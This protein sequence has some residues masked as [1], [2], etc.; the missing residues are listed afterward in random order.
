MMQAEQMRQMKI[1]V[2]HLIAF[3]QQKI[4]ALN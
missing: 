1:F 2:L 3:A 4:D